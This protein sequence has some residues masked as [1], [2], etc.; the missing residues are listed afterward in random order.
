MFYLVYRANVYIYIYIYLSLSPSSSVVRRRLSSSVVRRPGRP[1]SWPSV[2][3][4][5]PSSSLSVIVVVVRHT[6]YITCHCLFV[7]VVSHDCF[8]VLWCLCSKLTRWECVA[9]NRFRKNCNLLKREP[10]T[11]LVDGN[12][13]KH[14]AI[15][16]YRTNRVRHICVRS[17]EFV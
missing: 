15:Q 1:S 2:V 9:N 13:L 14:L 11:N 17:K 12:V 6:T 10:T 16:E 5:R 4:R 8:E 3:C 7:E